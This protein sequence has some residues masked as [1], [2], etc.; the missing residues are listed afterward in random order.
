MEPNNLQQYNYGHNEDGRRDGE[1]FPHVTY[2][3]YLDLL[4]LDFLRFLLDGL[5]TF[6]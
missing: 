6:R 2:P 1:H 5:N 4:L 3:F